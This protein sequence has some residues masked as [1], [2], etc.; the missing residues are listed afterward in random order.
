MNSLK[1]NKISLRN[2]HPKHR[3]DL[4]RG[5]CANKTPFSFSVYAHGHQI[6]K[7]LGVKGHQPLN[8]Q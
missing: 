5:K 8:P 3:M 7:K 2:V 1:E 6:K 4:R